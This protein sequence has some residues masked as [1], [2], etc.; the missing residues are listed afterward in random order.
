MTAHDPKRAFG[1][2]PKLAPRFGKIWELDVDYSAWLMLWF[3]EG[4]TAR[5]AGA[6][7]EICIKVMPQTETEKTLLVECTLADVPKDMSELA[8]CYLRPVRSVV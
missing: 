3:C 7:L 1:V 6:L 2:E 8:L 5:H 4:A